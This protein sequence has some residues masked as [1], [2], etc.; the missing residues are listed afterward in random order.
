MAEKKQSIF[1]RFLFGEEEQAKATQA[2]QAEDTLETPPAAAE[3]AA[4][5]PDAEEIL[6]GVNN[7]E[8]GIYIVK[9]LMAEQPGLD[10]NALLGILRITGVDVEEVLEDAGERMDTVGAEVERVSLEYD[11]IREEARAQ[12]AEMREVIVQLKDKIALL[13]KEIARKQTVGTALRVQGA[14]MIAEIEVLKKIL[15]GE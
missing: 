3:E 15:K 8:G 10:R 4:P 5:D 12:I 13:E 9:S 14:A 7:G 6:R 1:E 2:A 11:G